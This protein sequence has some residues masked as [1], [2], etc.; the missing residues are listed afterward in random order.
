MGVRGLG[1]RTRKRRRRS[2]W[3]PDWDLAKIKSRPKSWILDF[4]PKMG[5]AN[6]AFSVLTTTQ[7]LPRLQRRG[8][9]HQGWA[10]G[11]S[12]EPTGAT[13]AL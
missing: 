6:L 8:G 13:S 9:D 4:K 11:T 10:E 12:V 1:E 7:V 3:N 5:S 2:E